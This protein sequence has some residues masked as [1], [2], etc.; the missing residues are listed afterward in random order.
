MSMARSFTRCGISGLSLALLLAACT[1]GGPKG[2]PTRLTSTPPYSCAIVSVRMLRALSLPG[3]HMPLHSTR[4]LFTP[5][6][7]PSHRIYTCLV[8]GTHTWTWVVEEATRRPVLPPFDQV[9]ARLID[10]PR[11]VADGG[12]RDL[13]SP[14]SHHI[15][16]VFWLDHPHRHSLIVDVAIYAKTE[17]EP[18]RLPRRTMISL[19]RAFWKRCM[20]VRWCR[21]ARPP[22]TP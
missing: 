6:L 18:H 20:E 5:Y 1:R 15:S 11:S 14:N 8:R 17:P 10:L 12:Y 3:F 19:A 2:P 7:P 16:I 22:P 21:T 4:R 9:G 13:V